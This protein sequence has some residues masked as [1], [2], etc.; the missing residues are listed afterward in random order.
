M[1]SQAATYLAACPKSNRSY[2]AIEKAL[3][4]VRRTGNLDIPMSIRNAPTKMMKQWGYGKD[5]QYAHNDQRGWTP[6]QFL[7]DALK[8]EQFYVPSEHGQEGK[9]KESLEKRGKKYLNH[10]AETHTP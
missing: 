2:V 9:I 5:Y 6:H 10:N 4:A 1:L 7:P 3:E 8:D